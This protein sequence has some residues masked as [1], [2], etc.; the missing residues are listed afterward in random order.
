MGVGV[1][2]GEGVADLRLGVEGVVAEA[3]GVPQRLQ[4]VYSEQQWR[5]G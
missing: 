2:V 4:M 1:G 3:E 5:L